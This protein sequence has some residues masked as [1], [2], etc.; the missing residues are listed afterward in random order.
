M[1]MQCTGK[2]MIL[3]VDTASEGRSKRRKQGMVFG[4]RSRERRWDGHFLVLMLGIP[5]GNF[6]RV[7]GLAFDNT[8]LY[9]FNDHPT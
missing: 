7:I 6:G 5:Q 2:G 9:R 3:R 1:G 8:F 4:L